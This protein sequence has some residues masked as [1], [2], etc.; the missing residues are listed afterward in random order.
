MQFSKKHTIIGCPQKKSIH[1]VR[2]F[3]KIAPK[4]GRCD[5]FLAR[6]N[7]LIEIIE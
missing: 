6:E 7:G 5:L 4:E 1:R 3:R 2:A